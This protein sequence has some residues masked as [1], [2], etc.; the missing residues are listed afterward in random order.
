VPSCLAIDLTPSPL[1]AITRISTASS[2]V[3]I[4][5][6]EKAAILA[7]VGHFYFG[8]VGQYYFGANS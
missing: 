2:W 6:T 3:N 4:G 8:A 1:R 7:Q 5:G